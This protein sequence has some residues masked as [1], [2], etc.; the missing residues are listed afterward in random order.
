LLAIKLHSS[1]KRLT[2]IGAGHLLYAAF[3]W[4]FDHV[5]YVYAVFTWGMLIG[6]GLMTL[7]SL[8]QCALTLHL[9]EKMHIDWVGA[10][11][12][13]AWDE[14]ESTSFAGRLFRRIGKKQKAVFIFLCV[15]FDPFITT[16]Y[17]RKGR[18]DG[19]TAHDWRIF[20]YS[21]LIS[22]G[23]WICVSALLGNGISMLWQ[24]L[25]HIP[26]VTNWLTTWFTR[27]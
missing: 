14:Q 10:G 21:V 20:L 22:N 8:I 2:I 17:F 1:Y 24:W 6:G 19:L 23:W 5:I 12:L 7:F 27:A 16:A 18:F 13:H 25:S 4:L 9:Y 11:A 15:F 3:N 26:L